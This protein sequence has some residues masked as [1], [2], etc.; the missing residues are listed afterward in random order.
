[1][2]DLVYDVPNMSGPFQGS[3]PPGRPAADLGPEW[4]AGVTVCDDLSGLDLAH[5][6]AE[7]SPERRAHALGYR[8]ERDRRLSVAA[9]L[10]LKEALGKGYGLVGNPRLGRGRNGKPF[11]P[12]HPE[13][14]F[15]LSHCPRAAVCAVADSPVGID[16]EE[17]A[18]V[19]WEVARRVLSEEEQNAVRTSSEPD[20]AFVRY[21]TR[22]EAF[23]KLTGDGID[24]SRL[25]MLLP[26]VHGVAFETV[27]HRR[28]GYA[29]T[30]AT[31]ARVSAGMGRFVV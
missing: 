3:R 23:A 17:I 1:M 12:D 11:L 14:H 22:K 27:I 8:L 7:I 4:P 10:L 13:I 6:L 28:R 19:D 24:D 20:V 31:A 16:V 15:N 29:V 9:Y 18:P 30:L 26:E 21:W 5:A 2:P 25:P